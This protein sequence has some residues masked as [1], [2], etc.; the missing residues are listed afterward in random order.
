MIGEICNNYKL[1]QIIV[2]DKESS[3]LCLYRAVQN[4]GCNG[5]PIYILIAIHLY[6]KYWSFDQL[7]SLR[8]N[9][10]REVIKIKYKCIA[11]VAIRK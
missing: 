2:Y 10:L 6:I 4:V 5:F 9:F 1:V 11:K 8:I 7:F 3:E